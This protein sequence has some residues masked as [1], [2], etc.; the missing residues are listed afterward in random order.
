MKRLDGRA[1]E[2][3]RPLSIIYDRYGFADASLIF[4][5]GNTVIMASV[6]LSQGVPPFLKGQGIGWLSAEY[7]MLPSATQQRTMREAVKG[8][9]DGRSVE[10]SRLIGR[11][12]R[13]IV[14]LTLIGERTITIDCDVLQA[15]GGTRVASI[16]AAS[17][18]LEKACERWISQGIITQ[19]ICKDRI[20]GISV[21]VVDGQLLADLAYTEDCRADADFNFILS[22]QGALVEI[23]GTSEKA[24]IAWDVFEQLK[25]MAINGV[26]QILSK[27][28][29][30]EPSYTNPKQDLI[31]QHSQHAQQQNRSKN[32]E[33]NK[34]NNK[35]AL[36]SLGNRINTP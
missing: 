10:I 26:Q 28:A 19:S 14:D 20:V 5:L 11:C 1:P 22:A 27:T 32:F 24:P 31:K 2:D 8:Q 6:S 30:I 21:G 23:Q 35:P 25:G 16:T 18:A 13:S 12:L 33:Q 17:L 3:V 4:E 34:K 29:S 36:F 9:R 15:D 7:A